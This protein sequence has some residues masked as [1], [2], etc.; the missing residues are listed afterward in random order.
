D[1]DREPF[2]AVDLQEIR[3][4]LRRE[5]GLGHDEVGASGDLLAQAPGLVLQVRLGRVDG[6]GDREVR[7]PTNGRAGRVLAFVHLVD[8]PDQADR[9]EVVDGRR[10]G[11]VAETWRITGQGQDVPD[12]GGVRAEQLR[13]EAHQRPIPG[14]VVEDR[15]DT[16]LALDEVAQGHRAHADTRHGRVGDVDR[17]HPGFLQETGTLDRLRRV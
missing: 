17:V 4:D 16:D 12:A 15:L 1:R 2:L 7:G 9:V 10:V 8:D 3:P 5:D 13:L 14:G 6:A 11:I